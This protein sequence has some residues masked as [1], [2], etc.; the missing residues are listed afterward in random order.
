MVS[1]WHTE[2]CTPNYSATFKMCSRTERLLQVLEALPE[3]LA[4]VVLLSSPA[5]LESKVVQLSS[6][7][8]P[9]AVIAEIPGLAADCSLVRQCSG[10]SLELPVLSVCVD[11]TQAQDVLGI[12]TNGDVLATNSSEHATCEEGLSIGSIW[13]HAAAISPGNLN[14]LFYMQQRAGTLSCRLF[15]KSE[16]PLQHV[17]IA[18]PD[19]ACLVLSPASGTL[20]LKNA[21]FQGVKTPHVSS[22]HIE[23]ALLQVTY[24]GV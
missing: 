18:L 8:R 5:T 16:K 11:T 2:P 15:A 23:R 17:S 13:P 6:S 22:I 1:V 4:I 7:L 9:L 14:H 21:T 3:D 24:A 12:T 10:A 19:S 20:H